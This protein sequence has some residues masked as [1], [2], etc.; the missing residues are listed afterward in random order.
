MVE[1]LTQKGSFPISAGFRGLVGI[2]SMRL[3]SKTVW[4]RRRS[5]GVL[6]CLMYLPL[7]SFTGLYS[8]CFGGTDA[9]R[10]AALWHHFSTVR[11]AGRRNEQMS[12]VSMGK[13]RSA[14]VMAMAP[15]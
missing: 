15:E 6:C 11:M 13:V 1:M 8:G 14:P 9:R 5:S 10:T 12:R 4:L 7:L 2:F 3:G